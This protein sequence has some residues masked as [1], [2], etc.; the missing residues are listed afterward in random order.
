MEGILKKEIPIPIGGDKKRFQ[1]IL[2]SAVGTDTNIELERA[3][4]VSDA[5]WLDFFARALAKEIKLVTTADPFMTAF[6]PKISSA[7]SYKRNAGEIEDPIS[8]G[9]IFVETLNALYYGNPF[10]YGPGKDS[11]YMHMY[12]E[13]PATLFLY[14]R[15]TAGLPRYVGHIFVLPKEIEDYQK[16]TYDDDSFVYFVSIYKSVLEKALRKFSDRVIGDIIAYTKRLGEEYTSIVANPLPGPMEYILEKK[17][18][19]VLDRRVPGTFYIAHGNYVLPVK[20]G[21]RRSLQRKTRRRRRQ[22]YVK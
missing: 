11:H 8:S 2:E 18:F 12:R 14:Y 6:F 1:S 5:E 9:V 16:V 22:R 13:L 4:P 10:D 20:G 3:A 19:Q 17:G 21:A 15:Q 7:N